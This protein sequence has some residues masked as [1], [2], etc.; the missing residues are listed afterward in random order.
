[1]PG[2]SPAR[3]PACVGVLF[4]SCAVRLALPPALT[5][6]RPLSARHRDP[7]SRVDPRAPL[8]LREPLYLHN[9]IRPASA[10]KSQ[11]GRLSPR[12]LASYS[13]IIMQT[14][15]QST[16]SA[17]RTCPHRPRVLATLLRFLVPGTP[18]HLLPLS[19]CSSSWLVPCSWRLRLWP[20]LITGRFTPPTAP[21]ASRPPLHAWRA[22]TPHCIGAR[23]L[24][25]T[26]SLA[27]LSRTPRS[28]TLPFRIFPLMGQ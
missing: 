20:P 27:P 15:L 17:P 5:A 10:W 22:T 21:H 9:A 28:P 4:F 25:P 6:S 12:H 3:W 18:G 13:L 7:Q 19:A 2:P 14:T 8:R 11:A 16:S 24:S 23:Q 26:W 1:V